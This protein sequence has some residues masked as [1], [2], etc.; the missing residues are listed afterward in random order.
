MQLL[1]DA[2]NPP[3]DV[4]PVGHATGSG[5]PG[6]QNSLR[7]ARHVATEMSINSEKQIR[8]CRQVCAHTQGRRILSQ[9]RRVLNISFDVFVIMNC[10]LVHCH[11][12]LY[13]SDEY[14]VPVVLCC[15]GGVPS[16]DSWNFTKQD[17]YY[18]NDLADSRET[19]NT[20]FALI[21]VRKCVLI[22]EDN[23]RSLSVVSRRGVGTWSLLLSLSLDRASLGISDLLLRV[24]RDNPTASRFLRVGEFA[25]KCNFSVENVMAKFVID[26]PFCANTMLPRS[27]AS[28]VKNVRGFNTDLLELYT[29][30]GNIAFPV[31]PVCE[32][33]VKGV[34]NTEKMRDTVV[35]LLAHS[36]DSTITQY[37]A[38]LYVVSLCLDRPLDVKHG[39]MLEKACA[40]VARNKLRLLPRSEEECNMVNMEV[41]GW[42]GIVPA[43]LLAE[44]AW[45]VELISTALVS[46]TRHG[47]MVV[48][49]TWSPAIEID[50]LLLPRI[51]SLTENLASFIDMIS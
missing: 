13:G 4:Y 27:L 48:R 11:V 49:Y 24:S 16:T 45:F 1:I 31:G 14:I 33:H 35:S 29:I 26:A 32:I 38:R 17:T 25:G 10:L 12:A 23:V 47:N 51:R 8:V 5:F 15:R 30:Y 40:N 21:Y 9:I 39:C 2:C 37:V 3:G 20:E 7:F 34:R 41:V 6:K 43:E 50:E 19:T 44:N 46:V 18:V 42:S 36:S 22:T 28:L